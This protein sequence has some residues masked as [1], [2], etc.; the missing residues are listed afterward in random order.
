MLYSR[1][2]T[3]IPFLAYQ[4]VCMAGLRSDGSGLL[5]AVSRGISAAADQALAAEQLRNQIN[6]H[7]QA[8]LASRILS[9]DLKDSS[10][11]PLLDYQREFLQLALSCHALKFGLF[12]L[13]SGRE[14][15]YFFNAGLLCDGRAFQVLG[16][17]VTFVS[18]TCSLLS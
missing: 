15:P 10:V 3:K 4:A 11:A 2:I 14:S 9:T 1:Y 8:F 17:Y 13:K 7:R 16:R 12:K 5:V 6:D 18:R